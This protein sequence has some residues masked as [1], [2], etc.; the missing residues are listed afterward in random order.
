MSRL[1]F[2]ICLL[3]ACII[4]FSAM[5]PISALITA[6]IG[7][8]ASAFVFGLSCALTGIITWVATRALNKR[9][10]R[11]SFDRFALTLEEKI[12]R[13]YQRK[14]P[15]QTFDNLNLPEAPAAHQEPTATLHLWHDI[16]NKTPGYKILARVVVVVLISATA[17]AA[18]GALYGTLSR[19]NIAQQAVNMAVFAALLGALISPFLGD[20][21]R[22]APNILAKAPPVLNIWGDTEDTVPVL[23]LLTRFLGVTFFATLGGAVYG[24]LYT[25]SNAIGSH[26]RLHDALMGAIIGGLI[27]GLWIPLGMAFE[28]HFRRTLHKKTSNTD[29]IEPDH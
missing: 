20:F 15:R 7:N 18:F 26:D 27:V 11:P 12:R 3:I 14:G 13:E 4:F 8:S 19:T 28:G 10:I 16:D 1:R 29:S 22:T 6:L 21:T 5:G 24:A 2:T 23:V 25:A 17:G 9:W